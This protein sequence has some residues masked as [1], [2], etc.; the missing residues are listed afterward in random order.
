MR[1]AIAI[2]PF[3]LLAGCGPGTKLGT[4]AG[5]ECQLVHTPRYEVLG[6]TPYDRLWIEN[7]E[8]ALVRGCGQ[9][10]PLARPAALDRPIKRIAAKPIIQEPPEIATPKPK[11]KKKR[12]WQRK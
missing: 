4:I 11:P 7:T 3:L 5:G 2:I 1:Q 6:K 8:E 10:R 9:P 12:W